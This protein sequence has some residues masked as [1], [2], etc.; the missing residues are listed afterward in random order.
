MIS[1]FIYIIVC[2]YLRFLWFLCSSFE[3]LFLIFL[4][5]CVCFELCVCKRQ[6]Q[7]KK[8]KKERIEKEEQLKEVRHLQTNNGSR[9]LLP[10][11]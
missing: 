2:L 5:L 1:F 8:E 11:R 3:F 10:S 7:Q 6:E 4:F 9:D